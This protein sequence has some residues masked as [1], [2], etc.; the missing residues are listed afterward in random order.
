MTRASQKEREK[1][2]LLHFKELYLNFP[3][4]EIDD[5]E[6]PD[7][8]VNVR[9]GKK[10]GIEIVELFAKAN[11]IDNLKS[12]ALQSEL[13]TLSKI[14]FEKTYGL[15]LDV[16]LIFQSNMRCS[17][18][19]KLRYSE[20]IANDI[21]NCFHKINY[22]IL[23]PQSFL[24]NNLSSSFLEEI[25]IYPRKLNKGV[26]DSGRAALL[27]DLKPEEI[28]SVISLKEEKLNTINK[29]C[30]E[31]WLL[32]IEPFDKLHFDSIPV[33]SDVNS[34]FEK[35]FFLRTLFDEIRQIK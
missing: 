6:T 22:K 21:Y 7:F 28:K 9:T 20:K 4:G 19:N 2:F 17:K 14:F 33:V 1:I 3:L 10:I 11:S 26:W 24:K 32:I 31:T 34:G 15:Q 8:I 18:S 35:I 16:I 5:D 25:M 29:K 30:H 12:T 23:E 13:T 27:R